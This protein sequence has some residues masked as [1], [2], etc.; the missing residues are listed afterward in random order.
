MILVTGSTGRIG[1]NV[2]HG[3]ALK[4][5]PV[6]ALIHN[7]T[8]AEWA[9]WA[10]VE[11]VIGDFAKPSTLAVALDGVTTA[12]LLSTTGPEQANLQKAFVDAAVRAGVKHVV[13]ISLLGARLDAPGRF[14]RRHAEVEERLAA[15]G[16]RITVLR[17]NAFMQGVLVRTRPSLDTH[18]FRSVVKPTTKVSFVDLRDVADAAVAKLVEPDGPSAT[19]ELTGPEPL[20][21]AAM[22]EAFARN[23]E[24]PIACEYIDEA[25]LRNEMSRA[26]TSDDSIGGTLES[27]AW[28]DSGEA[29][30]VND[31][32]AHI[33]GHLPRTFDRFVADNAK[34]LK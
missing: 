2:V 24:R 16:M 31:A 21:G 13:K 7:G 32:I 27:V 8:G 5:L 1:R 11:G 12:L 33:T 15:S 10:N 4:E 6:R 14:H 9:H 30:L 20:T 28:F 29:A 18:T 34:R 19:I 25:A 22:A 26:G 23:L 3:L 17:A